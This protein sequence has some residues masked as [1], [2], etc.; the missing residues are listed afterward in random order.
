MIS[1][2]RRACFYAEATRDLFI[3]LPDED[4]EYGKGDLVG[5]LRLCLYGTR[6]AAL[7]WQETLSN[8]LIDNGFVRGVGFPSVFYHPE[9]DVW[10]LVHGDDYCS[11]G[12]DAALAWLEKVLTQKYEIKT[13]RVGHAAGQASEGQILNREVRATDKAFELEADQRHAEF[14]VE[15]LNLSSGKGRDAWRR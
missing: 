9:R 1:D 13:Q 14:I 5:K 11:A 4:A 15:Q 6:D 12:D 7:N 10:T 2:V 8:H 3:E